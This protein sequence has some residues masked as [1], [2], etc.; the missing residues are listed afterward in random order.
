MAGLAIAHEWL[1]VRA[2][3]EKTFEAMAQAYPD[4]DLYAL[5]WDREAQFDFSGRPVTT[6]FLD[7]W[8]AA[9]RT[10]GADLAADVAGL[11]G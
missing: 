9:A 11:E 8:P 6:T 1:A 4:A 10:A 7:R 2:G 3:S 5:T